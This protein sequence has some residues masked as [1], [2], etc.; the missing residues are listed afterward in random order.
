VTLKNPEP[1]PTATAAVGGNA[2]SEQTAQASPTALA[3]PEVDNM[4]DMRD[5][6]EQ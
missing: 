3:A 2:E 6:W 1:E 5:L 4:R